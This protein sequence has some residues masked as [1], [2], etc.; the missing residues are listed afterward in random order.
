M[1]GISLKIENCCSIWIWGKINKKFW[2]ALLKGWLG[3]RKHPGLAR[4]PI[5][6]VIPVKT[7]YSSCIFGTGGIL[8]YFWA[9]LCVLHGG[10]ICAAFCLSHL[11]KIHH[12]I[13]I[14]IS[15]SIIAR[16]LKLYHS[17]KPFFVHLGKIPTTLYEIYFYSTGRLIQ[18][19]HL[20]KIHIW[21][22][23]DKKLC[24]QV[25]MVLFRWQVGLIANVKLHFHKNLL[26]FL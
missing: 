5:F 25:G 16:S 19:S 24:Q 10:L 13:E 3:N 15:E 1:L 23:S 18:I 2:V 22:H 6:P 14:H 21:L 9:H 12:L 11:I 8:L 20:I 4:P 17:M 7:A 26:Y